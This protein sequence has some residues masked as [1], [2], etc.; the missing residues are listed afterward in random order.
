MKRCPACG[1]LC[2]DDANF[3]TRCQAKLEDAQEGMT[4][5][6][7]VSSPDEVR[8]SIEGTHFVM[9]S[10]SMLCL[11][12]CAL[13]V[14]YFFW[15]RQAVEYLYHLE[16]NIWRTIGVV[17]V[18]VFFACIEVIGVFV[19]RIYAAIVT[20]V[21]AIAAIRQKTHGAI[22][23]LT[24]AFAQIRG[25]ACFDGGILFVSFACLLIGEAI[26]SLN[27]LCA[28]FVFVITDILIAIALWMIIGNL[29]DEKNGDNKK[30]RSKRT[31]TLLA[32]F[33]GGFGMHKDYLDQTVAGDL[34][35]VFHLTFIPTIIGI[36]EGVMLLTMSEQD[37]NAKYNGVSYA[38][39]QNFYHQPQ[40]PAVIIQ[41]P[42]A[43][44]EAAQAV[45]YVRPAANTVA[46]GN[47]CA[48][49][50]NRFQP[51]ARYCDRCGASVGLAP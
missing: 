21:G 34:Y 7:K 47:V 26:L 28:L 10:G 51:G 18:P 50:G 14:G 40:Q 31:A 45:P 24:D 12:I 44:P 41:M 23:S 35:C 19:A 2:D 16:S 9:A 33:L 43:Q 25:V 42:V 8:Q 30:V 22:G 3:C 29:K 37:F 48:Q 38:Q 4:V 39:P 17:S 46:S 11:F 1:T 32:F 5:P 6:T 20:F 27:L 13:S 15:A 49:C 36:I